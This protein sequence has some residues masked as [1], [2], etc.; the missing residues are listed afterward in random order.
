MHGEFSGIFQMFFKKNIVNRWYLL[1]PA[2]LL[3]LYIVI[4]AATISLNW[5]E[6]N[7]FFEYVRTPNWLPQDFNYMLAN[8][9]LLNTWLM[10]CSVTIF[11]ESEFALRL[12]N[13]LASLLYFFSVATI[14]QKLFEKKGQ[15]LFAFFMLCLN[16]FVLDFF[17]VARGYGLALAF[18]MG[19]MSQ[20]TNYI[21]GKNEIRQGIY[22]QLFFIAALLA[23]FTFVHVLLSCSVLLMMNRLFFHRSDRPYRSIIGFSI[24]PVIA[25][26]I[27]FPFLKQLKN[28]GALFYGEEI[29]SLAETF[30]SLTRCS[31]YGAVYSS[32]FLPIMTILVSAVPLIAVIHIMRNALT[33]QKTNQGRWMVFITLTLFFTIVGPMFLHLIFKTNYLSGRTALFYL[34]LLILSFLGLLLI[35]N[36]SIRNVALTGIAVLSLVHFSFTANFYS[37]YDWK[38]QADVKNA[39][40][41]LKDQKIPNDQK[42][43]AQIISTDLP[44]EKQI[45]YYRMRFDMKQ[46]SHAGRNENVPN[47]SFY[48]LPILN[49]DTIV[50]TDFLL[51]YYEHTETLLFRKREPH[52][53]NLK[54]VKQVWQD[55]EHEDAFPQLKRDTIFIGEQGTFAGN[56]FPYSISVGMTIPD[57]VKGNLVASLNCRLFY[58]TRNTSALLV[59]SFDNGKSESWEAM[60]IT[61]LP[62]QPGVWS[63]TNWTRPVPAG[64][65]KISVF[66]WNRDQK[67]V[68]MD[69]VGIRLLR[70]V[71]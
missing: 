31:L 71:E 42:V 68:L 38:E 25:L 44:F 45:N 64:T 16:P 9:H 3:F 29:K 34:P 52:P 24:L 69:N 65:K 43:Y 23:N 48:Y 70:V 62:E 17:C 22:A 41:L 6:A 12:P 35:S 21:F 26:A 33:V 40:L 47:C 63:L 19:G 36:A 27:L 50:N 30:L 14:L 37:C 55:F 1:L 8:D 57:S 28:A 20:I 15:I 13:V 7:T 53:E 51:F 39:M 66:L 10:K 46:F 5:D 11:G 32:V 49:K 2:V 54:I 56:H 61:E 67:I 18:M 60:H 4:R 59:F 58:Y